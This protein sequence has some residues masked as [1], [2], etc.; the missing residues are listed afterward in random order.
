MGYWGAA[1]DALKLLKRGEEKKL[2]QRGSGQVV[3][4]IMDQITVS[5]SQA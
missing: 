5:T 4:G 1:G 2:I 3:R